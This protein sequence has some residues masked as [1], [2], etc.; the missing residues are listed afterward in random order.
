MTRIS[1]YASQKTGG[2]SRSTDKFF[3]KIDLPINSE[4]MMDNRKKSSLTAT[5][6]L[7]SLISVAVI[8]LHAGGGVSG[9]VMPCKQPPTMHTSR[10]SRTNIRWD[11]HDGNIAIGIMRRNQQSSKNNGEAVEPDLFDYFDPLLSPH[12]YPNGIGA[13]GITNDNTI[14]S[15]VRYDD[16]EEEENT[17]PSLSL[18]GDDLGWGSSSRSDVPKKSYQLKKPFGISLPGSNDD[19]DVE[20]ELPVDMRKKVPPSSAIRTDRL[21]IDTSAIFDPTLSPHLYTNGYVPD[22]IIGDDAALLG[23]NDNEDNDNNNNNKETVTIGILLMDHGSRNVA[24]NER[25]HELAKLYQNQFTAAITQTK[26]VRVV[27]KAAHMEIALPSIED[28]LSALLQENVEEIICHPY[29]LSPGRHV[30]EDIPQL[31][32]AAIEALSISIP[33]RTTRPIG[34]ETSIMIHAI[35]SLVNEA[36][37]HLQRK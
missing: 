13:S 2:T 25:L 26:H 20:D 30:V 27:V 35:N 8:H 14:K 4:I 24:S 11:K 37:E 10:R 3:I 16:D 15:L 6:Q 18:K 29:F 28:G 17:T 19:D 1:K 9:L 21:N 12:A 32:N 23:I 33:V 5:M 22:V 34:S 36:S 31:V 7:L